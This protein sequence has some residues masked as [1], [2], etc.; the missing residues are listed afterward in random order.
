MSKPDAPVFTCQYFALGEKFGFS[1]HDG[2]LTSEFQPMLVT[3]DT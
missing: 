1:E 3:P 2:D